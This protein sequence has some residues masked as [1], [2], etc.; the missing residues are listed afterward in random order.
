MAKVTFSGILKI[1]PDEKL[2]NALECLNKSLPT[3]AQPLLR[4]HLHVTLINQKFLREHK[5]LLRSA[6]FSDCP[7]PLFSTKVF[8][9]SRQGKTSWIV[10]LLNQEEMQQYVIGFKKEF[11]LK[12]DEDRLFHFSLANLDGN[13]FSSVGDVCLAD[14]K[15]L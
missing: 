12:F 4:E 2:M 11:K 14:I 1:V 15:E 5:M 3:E 10:P 6:V 13:P 7:E 9:V 8:K